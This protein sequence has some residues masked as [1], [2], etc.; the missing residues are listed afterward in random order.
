MFCV[1]NILPTDL[2][3]TKI[4]GFQFIFGYE[5][6]LVWNAFENILGFS[7]RFLVSLVLENNEL[8]EINQTNRKYPSF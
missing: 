1:L 2:N 7:V 4:I 5:F 6:G 3:Q 8:S